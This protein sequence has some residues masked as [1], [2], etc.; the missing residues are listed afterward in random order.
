MNEPYE[1]DYRQSAIS[2]HGV[3]ATRPY[4]AG[5]KVMEISLQAVSQPINNTN[6]SCDS[7]CGV[8]YTTVFALRDIVPDEEIT[9]NYRMLKISVEPEEFQCHCGSK[10]CAGY[11]NIR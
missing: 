7:N 5:E 6:H 2:G 3:F 4:K 10:H 8:H 1:V 11:I 9:I